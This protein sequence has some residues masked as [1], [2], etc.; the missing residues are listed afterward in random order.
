MA[1]S[2]FDIAIIGGTPAAGMVAALL[3]R[4]GRR[5]LHLATAKPCDPW[6]SS[7]LFLRKLL[8]TLS[9]QSCLVAP[10]PFQVLSSRARITI[11]PAVPLADELAREF[12][13]AADRV[14]AVLAEL[15]ALGGRLEAL[16]W[17]HGGLPADTIRGR[18][19]WRWLCLRRKFATA[20][21]ATPLAARLHTLPEAAAEWLTD[22]FQ[23]LAMQP[24]TALSVADGALLWAQ[25]RHPE[26]VSVGELTA[27]LQKRFEQFHGVTTAVESLAA[28][29]HRNGQ[30]FGSLHNGGSCQAGQLILG[31]CDQE[32]PGHGFPAPPQTLTPPQQLLTSPL[33]GQLSPLLEG[34][35]IVGGRLPLRLLFTTAPAGLSAHLSASVL[36]DEAQIRRQLEPVL[37]YARYTLQVQTTGRT[38]VRLANPAATAPSLFKLP[39]H[40]GSRLWCLDPAALLP[41][42]GSGGAPLLA[43]TLL[44]R[45]QPA[46]GSRHR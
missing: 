41:Q 17:E 26:A 27:L 2:R 44:R 46:A 42:L 37:P 33:D 16:L 3:A 23:G 20:S 9:G 13:A 10:Q 22:L 8:E 38:T 6:Q 31:D 28:L 36:A 30:W 45:L 15:E 21:L 40:P 34:R 19:G 35:V 14:G 43:W 7:S 39:L 24:L 25:A 32:L 5:V 4:H 11:H 12:G 29:E 1:Q 18:A